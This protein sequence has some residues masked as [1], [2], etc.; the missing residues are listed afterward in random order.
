MSYLTVPT[1]SIMLSGICERAS[2]AHLHLLHTCPVHMRGAFF[3]W[4]LPSAAKQIYVSS[5][6]ESG[7]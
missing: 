4:A 3:S 5:A 1:G 6:S 2:E 7:H